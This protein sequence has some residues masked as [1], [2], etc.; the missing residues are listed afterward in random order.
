MYAAGTSQQV[1][2]LL[3]RPDLYIRLR[4][5]VV[6]GSSFNLQC[7]NGLQ[8]LLARVAE[9]VDLASHCLVQSHDL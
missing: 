5:A 3:L 8:L 1:T 2:P 9:L 7:C 6:H 4:N